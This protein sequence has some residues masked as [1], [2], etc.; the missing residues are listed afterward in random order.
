M[1]WL[2]VP[3]QDFIFRNHSYLLYISV[4]QDTQ[5]AQEESP[6]FFNKQ[7]LRN[8]T[9]LGFHACDIRE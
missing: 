4:P 6:I 9:L 5:R 8:L 3:Y 7:Y 1:E 2:K